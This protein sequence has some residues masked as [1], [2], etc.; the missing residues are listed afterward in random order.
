[1][2][3]VILII[4]STFAG[5]GFERGEKDAEHVEKQTT[6]TQSLESEEN[7]EIEQVE[8]EHDTQDDINYDEIYDALGPDPRFD[9]LKRFGITGRLDYL[10]F[11]ELIDDASHVML[12][13]C[14]DKYAVSAKICAE[15]EVIE[16]FKGSIYDK[17]IQVVGTNEFY[18]MINSDKINDANDCYRDNLFKYDVGETYLLVTQRYY[19]VYSVYDQHNLMRNIYIP[20]DSIEDAIVYHKETLAE[21]STAASAEVFANYDTLIAYV[22]SLIA[23]D[24]TPSNTEQEYILTENL[25]EIVE[26]S[27]YVMRIKTW[28]MDYRHCYGEI[29]ASQGGIPVK[30][31]YFDDYVFC[32]VSL[33]ET[34]KGQKEEREFF[35]INIPCDF[36]VVRGGEYIVFVNREEIGPYKVT[37]K[38]SIFPVTDTEK[39]KEIE[40]LL[41]K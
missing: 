10:S 24:T 38:N 6:E 27:E 35:Y 19:S 37:T 31:D 40:A 4:V 12:A 13:K 28:I 17:K 14:V 41:K 23:Q 7:S 15:F 25:E 18:D 33:T 3:L 22:K 16:V 1:M 20:K 29:I 9:T 34:L 26:R 30:R 11:E 36:E 5:C 39:V 21:S 8:S 2:M 32:T